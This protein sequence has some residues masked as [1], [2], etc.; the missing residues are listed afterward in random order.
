MNLFSARRLVLVAVCVSI[1]YAGNGLAWV[2]K[3][4]YPNAITPA[5][6]T[7]SDA[8]DLRRT[9]L[10]HRISNAHRQSMQLGWGGVAPPRQPGID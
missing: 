9:P 10:F 7:S 6:P 4:H 1:P 8:Q 5:L 3:S 2:A